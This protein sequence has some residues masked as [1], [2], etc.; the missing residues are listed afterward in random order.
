MNDIPNSLAGRDLA[1]VLHP[2]TNA[3]AH[4]RNGPV[5]LARGQGVHVFDDAD[6]EY[7]EAMSGLWS[8][9]LGFSEPRLVEAATRQLQTLPFMH[10][11]SGKSHEPSILLAEKLCAMTGLDRVFFTNSGSE[12][13]DTVIKMVWFRNNAIGKPE[14][15]KFIARLNG[16]HGVT[17]ASASLTGLPGNHRGFDLPLPFVHHVTTP[18]HYRFADEGESEEAFATRLAEELEAKIVAEGPETVAAFIGEPVIGAGGVLVPPKGYWEKV[19]AVCRKYD[20]LVV[21]DEV[22]CGFGRT[23][24]MFGSQTFG[25]EPD[26]MVLSK[27]ITSSYQPLAAVVF[28][29]AIYQDIADGSAALGTFGH[30]YTASGH[31][32]A[33]AVGLE[34]LAII[35][36]RGLVD[37]AA[38]MGEVLRAGLAKWQDHPMV[39]EVRGVGLIAAVEFVADKQTRAK[40]DPIGKFGQEVFRV[41]HEHGLIIR[42]I[43]DTIAFCPPL[44]ITEEEVHELLRR[45]EATVRQVAATCR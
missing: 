18:H 7:I 30:G 34:N 8:V 17:V 20:V 6:R 16:Y 14:K 31:P 23:G 33:T 28:R 39:G 40:F 38:A 29:D 24:R 11:F 44:I 25:I 13:N 26:I 36:E 41:G 1:H 37:H 5:V 27:Q 9:A 22:I 35:E 4:E 10:T 21:A 45:F 32:V 19:Q 2:Y 43:G 3:R 15:K 42:A 12:A